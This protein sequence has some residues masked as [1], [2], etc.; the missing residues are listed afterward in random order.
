MRLWFFSA[1][2]AVFLPLSCSRSYVAISSKKG[3]AEQKDVSTSI[4]DKKRAPNRLIVDEAA[5]G[6]DDNS[7]VAMHNDRMTELGLF[8][9]DTVLLK[10]K[11]G[12]E[13]VCLVLADDTVDAGS[14]RMN[15]CVRKNLRVRLSDLVTVNPCPDLPYGERVHVL[16]IDDTIEGVTGNLFDAYLEPYFKMAY[17][18]IKKGDLFIVRENMHPV[19]F[20]VVET[21]PPDMCIVAKTTKI[22]CEGEPIRREDEER[23]VFCIPAS[24]RMHRPDVALVVVV[25]D[26]GQLGRGWLR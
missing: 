16:P 10:G 9:G 25:V 5:S 19:E 23:Y 14:I 17:R 11:R 2:C 4:M 13:T 8:R 20:K 12:K 22:H 6:N 7:V 24:L 1:R 3:D 15:K 21:D 26:V 18:P